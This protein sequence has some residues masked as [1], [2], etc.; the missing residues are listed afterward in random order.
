MIPSLLRPHVLI[1]VFKCFPMFELNTEATPLLRLF[2]SDPVMAA[3][4]RFHCIISNMPTMNISETYW[5][6]EETTKQNNKN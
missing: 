2:P 5:V 3:L 6:G 4:P 1:P